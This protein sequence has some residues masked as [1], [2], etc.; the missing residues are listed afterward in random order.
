MSIHTFIRLSSFFIILIYEFDADASMLHFKLPVQ[1]PSQ[2][3]TQNLH[4]LYGLLLVHIRCIVKGV[5][6]AYYWLFHHN[7]APCH[8]KISE[9][10]HMVYKS[11]DVYHR[12]IIQKTALLKC[13]VIHTLQYK[14]NRATLC[15]KM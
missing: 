2:L 6:I 3:G 14:L 4:S 5:T 7:N 9:A 8:T 10:H 15:K 12:S 11:G 1:T 13:V